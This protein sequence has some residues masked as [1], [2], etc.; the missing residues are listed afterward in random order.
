MA[1]EIRFQAK[2]WNSLRRHLLQSREEQVGFA[3]CS[4]ATRPGRSIFTVRDSYLA[5]PTDFDIQSTYHITLTDDALAKL[6]K[7]ASDAKACLVEFHSHPLPDGDVE[8][9]PS[10]LAGLKDLVPYIRWRLKG[11]PYAAV[12][13][14]PNG[15]DALAWTLPGTQATSVDGIWAGR[16]RITPTHLTIDGMERIHGHI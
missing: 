14:G 7:S 1:T 8:F 2:A 12:V 4:Y 6:I 10:D 5:S 3:F 9:S 11:Q 15:I 13:V 16:R